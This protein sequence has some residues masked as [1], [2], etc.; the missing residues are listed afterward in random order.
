MNDISI[1]NGNIK[2]FITG[3]NHLVVFAMIYDDNEYKMQI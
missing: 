1:V 3:G 2:Q